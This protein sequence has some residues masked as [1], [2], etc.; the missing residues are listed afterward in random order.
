MEPAPD[1]D[2][3]R[4]RCVFFVSDHTG[5]TAEVL[6]RSL[7]SRF[8]GLQ[9]RTATRSFID[10]PDKAVAL[11]E[12]LEALSPPALVFSTVADADVAACFRGRSFVHFDLFA[13]FLEPLA[14]AL[15]REP[16]AQV[17]VFHGVHDGAAYYARIDAVE[18]ALATDDGV[19]VTRYDRA[20]LIMVGVSRAGKTPTCLYLAM[21]YGVCAANYPLTEEDFEADELPAALRPHR[22]KLHGLSIDPLRLHALRGAR[23]PDSGY[24]AL[25]R[26][27]AEVRAAEALF[28]RYRVPFLNTTATS[29]EE[30]AARVRQNAGLARR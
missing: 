1:P 20:D 6:G 9:A 27:R 12:E 11:V 4:G 7:L 19:G 2:A 25:A 23:R 29:V 17:G 3:A 26:C 22:A 30:I 10:T 28:R 8:D 14:G 13:P 24:A 18:F 5:V 16:S 21:Q 15:G